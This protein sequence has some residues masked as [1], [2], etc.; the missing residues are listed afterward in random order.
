MEN[1]DSLYSK[2][3][4]STGIST[5]SRDRV[6]G[7]LFFAL[8]GESFNG[9]KFAAAALESGASW[10]VV[11]EPKVAVDQRYI[12][13]EDVLESLQQLALHHRRQFTIPILS[14]T[15][16][17]GKTTT[18]ELI[19]TV[20]STKHKVLYSEGNFNNHIG[21]PLTLLRLTKEFDL[22]VIEIGSSA[23]GEIAKLV[24]IVEPNYGLIT[25][26]GKA[27]LL[28]FHSLD[29]VIKEKGEL[30]NWVAKGGGTLFYNV[31]DP[32]IEQMVNQ[33]EGVNRVPY[34]LTLSA[35][36]IEHAPSNSPYLNL[37]LADSIIVKS[38]FV[39]NYNSINIL[40]ALKVGEYFGCNLADSV[41]AIE[42]Y[43]PTNMRSQLV[44][45]AHNRLIVDAYN[46]NPVSMKLSL[47]SFIKLS[48]NN[49]GVILGDMREL[50]EDSAI[51]HIAL[52]ELVEK[53]NFNLVFLVGLE[54]SS[55]A[56][57]SPHLLNHAKLFDNVGHLV[58]WLKENP[59]AGKTILIKGSRGIELERC[60][61]LI[62]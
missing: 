60:I 26:I 7:T 20:L 16:S 22:A 48:G 19:A 21:A 57:K 28:G 51:E 59:V 4:A 8:K 44:E 6:E 25:N 10:A 39:G 54:L 49:K 52:L 23:P 32:I 45:G 33:K 56:K 2:F 47:E 58:E 43:T 1:I 12:L 46:A 11:D 5:D 35:A 42:H 55:A 29:G 15:G 38:K 36:K 27:H 41:A 14:L 31:D 3:L 24:S 61:D 34:G 18:K 30:F 17:N 40:A 9:N 50:G 13:V 62:K 37:K 53:L